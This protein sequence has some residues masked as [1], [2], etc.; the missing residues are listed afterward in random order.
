MP[1]Q[2]TIRGTTHR[3]ADLRTLMARATRLRSGD[4]LAG[5]AAETA[6]QAA[7]A[8]CALADLPLARFLDEALVPYEACEVT[9]LLLDTHDAAA[10]APVSHLTVG[11]LPRLAAVGQR[12]A[13]AAG[14][15]GARPAA[16]DGG[17]GVQDH[18]QPGSGARGAQVPRRDEIPQHHRP[19]RHDGGAAAAE[20][21]APTIRT[22]SPP[23]SWTG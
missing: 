7:A 16:R 11:G 2:H 3:F 22:A 21:P 14:R 5:I 19:A 20:P 6:E 12:D 8:R 23:R 9:R 18:A 15:A 17:C 4:Q 10:F 1:F 13:R